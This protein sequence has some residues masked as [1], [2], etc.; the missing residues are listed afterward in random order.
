MP[1]AT[2]L[3]VP[4]VL[5]AAVMHATWNAVVKA[6]AGDRLTTQALVIWTGCIAGALAIPFFAI[7]A[8]ASWPFIALSTLAHTGYYLFLLLAYKNG[9]LSRVYPIARGTA[10]VL[11]AVGA[12]LFAGERLS[13]VQAAGVAL[14][15]FGIVSLAFERG[16]PQGRDRHAVA[17]A[18]TTGLF[19]TAY[20]LVDG[21]GV[22]LSGSPI[23]YIAWLFAIEGL[24][25]VLGA[26]LLHRAPRLSAPPGNWVKAIGGGIIATLGYGIAI[27]AMN[28]GAFAGIVSL[29]ETSVIF[30]AAIG[31]L[32]LGERFGPRRYLA[33]ALVAGGNLLLH[34]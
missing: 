2:T 28:L 10:P 7:P 19:I 18:V 26:L 13:L 16:L 12:A 22:R 17:A 31:A 5:L 34:L 33:A 30:G 25:F 1:L 11:V 15:S 27:W 21:I 9:E 23:G 4:L 20:T 3:V 29:R 32:F 6:A 14:V 8:R 24:P